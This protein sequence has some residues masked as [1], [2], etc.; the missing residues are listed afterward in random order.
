M[1]SE[2]FAMEQQF[3]KESL[4]TTYKMTRKPTRGGMVQTHTGRNI[5][6]MKNR[7]NKT[8]H[9]V[10]LFLVA[11]IMLAPQVRE[12]LFEKWAPGLQEYIMLIPAEEF[13][14]LSE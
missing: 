7:R 5:D 14:Y 13:S 8:R 12:N 1:K 11:F 9:L 2:N 6:L 10:L 4:D 3:H